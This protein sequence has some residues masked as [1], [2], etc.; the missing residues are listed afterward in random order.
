M[1][2]E[3]FGLGFTVESFSIWADPT[4]GTQGP[5]NQPAFV[6]SAEYDGPANQPSFVISSEYQG[7]ANQMDMLTLCAAFNVLSLPGQS[8]LSGPP[9]NMMSCP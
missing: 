9:A 5:A 4:E 1:A 6:I 8:T 3:N 7:P 2:N